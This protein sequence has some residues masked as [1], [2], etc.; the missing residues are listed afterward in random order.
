[1]FSFVCGRTNQ[2]EAGST[3]GSVALLSSFIFIIIFSVVLFLLLLLLL[4][5]YFF[6][7]TCSHSS[8]NPPKTLQVN[9]NRV[10]FMV[11]TGFYLVFAALTGCSVGC[12]SFCRVFGGFSWVSMVS[13]DCDG[14][15]RLL[16]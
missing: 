6:G 12:A 14:L 9:K 7:N 16:D 10:F 3:S 2:N 11:L 5:S 15:Q 4:V 8:T 13:V 1:M